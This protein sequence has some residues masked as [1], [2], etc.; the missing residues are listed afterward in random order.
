MTTDF[1]SCCNLPYRLHNGYIRIHTDHR[2]NRCPGSALVPRVTFESPWM[3]A[4]A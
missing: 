3:G 4:S 2:G 1:C